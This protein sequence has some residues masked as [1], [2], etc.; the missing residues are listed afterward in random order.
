[1]CTMIVEKAGISGSGKG[2]QGWFTLREV[3]VSYDHP[4]HVPL[5]HAL[6]IDFVNDSMGPS[7]RVAVELT[8]E[9]ARQLVQLIETALVRGEAHVESP[10]HL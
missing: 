4:F 6:N 3:A 5:E 7:A 2:S 9:S 8:P 10:G 1:M